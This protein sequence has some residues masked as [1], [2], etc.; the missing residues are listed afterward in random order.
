D[1]DFIELYNHSNE[2]LDISGCYL[3]DSRNTNK[4]VIGPNTILPPRGFISFNENQLGFALSSAGE[5]IYFRNASNT[6]VLDA[7]RFGPTATGVSSGRYPD[8]APGFIELAVRTPGTNNTSSLNREIVINKIMYSP[9][10]GDSDDEFVE[11][12][13]RGTNVVSVAGWRLAG[14]IS[15]NLP[16]DAAIPAGGYLVIARDAARLISRYPNLNANN[17]VGNYNGSLANGGERI[18]LEM[19]AVPFP[20]NSAGL[21]TNVDY[22]TVDEVTYVDGGRWG[23]WSDGG[24]SSLELIDPRSDNRLAAN[25]ADSDESSKAPWTIVS[26]RGVLDN[27]T[28]AADQL[29]VLLQGPGECLVDCGTAMLLAAV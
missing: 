12:Y 13:N 19:P 4:F 27:G 7:V 24:G 28:S 9:I 18:A 22:V 25:W 23:R 21:N 20:T 6:R 15:L 17:T 14:G 3:S 26:T 8:G 29:Q 2:Q 5:G 10:S 11:L 1:L 16:L